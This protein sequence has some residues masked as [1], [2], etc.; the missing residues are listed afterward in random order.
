MSENTK[1]Q[2][3]LW[4]ENISLMTRIQNSCHENPPSKILVW[5]GI[6][7]KNQKPA[8]VAWIQ[9]GLEPSTG[10]GKVIATDAP[11]YHKRLF[12]RCN[13]AS[14][15]TTQVKHAIIIVEIW[16]S[17]AHSHQPFPVMNS[18]L[19]SALFACSRIIQQWQIL[20]SWQLHLL[21]LA[22]S[23]G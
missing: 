12:N 23:E 3:P 6:C 9:W 17:I 15:D 2:T 1:K 13:M 11:I 10:E 5:W 18:N 20:T 8:A 7:E 21:I 22:F 14:M 16:I 4:I 19:T